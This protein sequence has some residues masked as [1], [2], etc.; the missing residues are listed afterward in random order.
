MFLKGGSGSNDS[1]SA[2]VVELKQK[3]VP[4]EDESAKKLQKKEKKVTDVQ[5]HEK[6]SKLTGLDAAGATAKAVSKEGRFMKLCWN[7][8]A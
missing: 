3:S 5:E 6:Q 8:S 1:S 7:Y 4:K 2:E